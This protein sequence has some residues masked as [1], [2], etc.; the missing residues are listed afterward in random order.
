MISYDRVKMVGLNLQTVIK[1]QIIN[2]K[3][4]SRHV[5]R[6]TDKQTETER[7]RDKGGG[8]RKRERERERERVFV[9]KE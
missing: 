4:A 6:Q 1:Q 9:Q 5:E 7:Q 3:N 2:Y 8:G